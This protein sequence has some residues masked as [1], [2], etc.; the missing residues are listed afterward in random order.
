MKAYWGVE[1]N[2][3]SFL[4]SAHDGG[5][6][7]AS[8]SSRFIPRE[9]AL[10][11]YWIGGCVEP[12]GSLD[13]VLKRKIPSTYRDSNPDHPARSPELYHWAIPAFTLNIQFF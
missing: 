12:R 6:W 2:P 4:A 13:A 7:S 1:V 8:R 3:H 5:E 9:R 10:V 11:S